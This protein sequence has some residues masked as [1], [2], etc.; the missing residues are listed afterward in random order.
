MKSRARA[1][2]VRD[3]LAFANTVGGGH[4]VFGVVDKTYVP[5]GLSLADDQ[6][7]TTTI[8][9]AIKDYILSDLQLMAAEYQI[10][11]L[12]WPEKRRFGIL[13]IPKYYRIAM[14]FLA[15][16]VAHLATQKGTTVEILFFCYS[17]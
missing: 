15:E 1:E 7:D 5:A 11:I 14:V 6:V 13:Y 3:I 10:Q 12:G 16:I 8:Y 9:K 2:L 4:I 17:H